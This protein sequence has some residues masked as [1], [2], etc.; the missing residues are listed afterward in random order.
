RVGAIIAALTLAVLSQCKA[1]DTF[2]PAYCAEGVVGFSTSTGFKQD[3]HFRLFKDAARKW[4][5]EVQTQYPSAEMPLRSREILSFDGT[6]IFSVLYSPDKVEFRPGGKA[7]VVPATRNEHPGRVCTGPYP[8]DHSSAVGAIW[9]AF[10]SADYLDDSRR[11]VGFP[12]LLT[13]NARSDPEAWS[14]DFD[15]AITNRGQRRLLHQGRFV[16]NTNHL[17]ANING[18]PELDEPSGREEI[19]KS[20]SKLQWLRVACS[21]SPLYAVYSAEE[22][23]EVGGS[24]VPS[25]FGSKIFL[26]G[27]SNV[28]WTI[29]GVVT[30]FP[31]PSAVQT[32]PELEGNVMVQDRRVR[33]KTPTAW[34]RD[35]FYSLD[36]SGWVIDT[37]NAKIVAALSRSSL[38]S[39]QSEAL[40]APK[41]RLALFLFLGGVLLPPLFFYLHHRKRHANIKSTLH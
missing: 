39:V 22:V 31:T 37:N 35:V 23:A 7:V 36:S 26:L 28:A 1:E 33:F 15:Y 5:L 25:R 29:Q 34:R 30:N 27:T 38:R 13:S 24:M 17:R 32:L 4:K 41:P 20:Q 6:N 9:L 18:Y 10:L 3:F 12:N 21:N 19:L 40:P 14:C 2:N 16:M 8:V 11:R